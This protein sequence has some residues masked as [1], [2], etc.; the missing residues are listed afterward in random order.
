MSEALS[1]KVLMKKRFKNLGQTHD[2]ADHACCENGS[3]D[4]KIC[5]S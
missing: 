1:R 3:R 5:E 4:W 2:L